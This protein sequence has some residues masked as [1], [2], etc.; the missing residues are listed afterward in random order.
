MRIFRLGVARITK[1][2]D[3]ELS[4]PLILIDIFAF[5]GYYS[6]DRYYNGLWDKLNNDDLAI[7]DRGYAA[8]PFM[9]S[10]ISSNKKFIIRCPKT[11]IISS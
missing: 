3:L 7:F 2:N 5:P 9:A 10:L 8:Y 11:N 6:K 1:N 4:S